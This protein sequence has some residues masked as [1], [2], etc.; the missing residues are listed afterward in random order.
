MTSL[1]FRHAGHSGLSGAVLL[2]NAEVGAS[3]HPAEI[4][5]VLPLALPT[6]PSAFQ[7][8]AR[9]QPQ[10]P[11]LGVQL[12]MSTLTIRTGKPSSETYVASLICPIHHEQGKKRSDLNVIVPFQYIYAFQEMPH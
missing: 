9:N 12:A 1:A 4:V 2:P 3:L 11:Q 8:R 5:E 10:N 7:G 6:D